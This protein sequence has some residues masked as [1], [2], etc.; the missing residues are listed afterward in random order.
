MSSE[1]TYEYGQFYGHEKER[2]YEY[3][4]FYGQ[5]S[6]RVKLEGEFKDW[7]ENGRLWNHR[8]YRDGILEGETKSWYE[9][10]RPQFQIFYKNGKSEGERKMWL[11]NGDLWGDLFYQDGKLIDSSFLFKRD[12]LLRLKKRLSIRPISP[13]DTMLIPELANIAIMK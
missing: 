9:N 4:Q 6:Y 13:L 11:D 3:G 7:H 5:E 1:Q 8:F 12:K 10:G 2:A